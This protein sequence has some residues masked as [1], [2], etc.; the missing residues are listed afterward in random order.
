MKLNL[1]EFVARGQRAQAEIDHIVQF[2]EMTDLD[3]VILRRRIHL[4]YRPW[5]HVRSQV[6]AELKRR[7]VKGA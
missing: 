2:A 1:E 5:T 6:E 4:S 3:L 7:Q